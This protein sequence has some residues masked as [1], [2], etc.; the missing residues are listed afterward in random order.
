M[1]DVGRGQQNESAERRQQKL[2]KT[3]ANAKI[4]VS[5]TG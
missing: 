1:I 3:V 4:N 5:K 2:V